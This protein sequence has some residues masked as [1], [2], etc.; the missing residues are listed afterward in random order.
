[1]TVVVDASVWVA[2][3]D[4]TDPFSD[5]SRRFLTG[6]AERAIPVAVPAIVHLEF[7]CALG[8]R[9]RDPE[10][11]R[12][13]GRTLLT[14]FQARVHPLDGTLLAEAS[15]AGTETRLR[16]GDALYLAVARREDASLIAWDDELRSRAQAVTPDAWSG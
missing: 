16:A 1:M 6:L 15:A 9:L 2:A 13:L 5:Q 14:P 10:R 7:A 11:A 3:A 4:S 12:H 8:R